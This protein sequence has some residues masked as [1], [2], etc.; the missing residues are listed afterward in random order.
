MSDDPEPM[1]VLAIED[2]TERSQREA[3]LPES[4]ERYRTLFESIDEGFCII[5]KVERG[6]DGLVD[7]RYVAANP[8]HLFLSLPS[9]AITLADP[10]SKSSCP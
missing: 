2:I 5:E 8:A 3:A 6:T 9:C 1:I 7:F 4:E 10:K